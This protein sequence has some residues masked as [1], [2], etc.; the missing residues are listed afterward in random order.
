MAASHL[1]VSIDE[2]T[3]LART[4]LGE[5]VLGKWRLDR[6]IGV[7]GMAAVFE[8]THHNGNRVAIKILHPDLAGFEEIRERFL[9]EGYAANRV[10]HSGVVAVRDEGTTADGAVFLVMDL[11]RGQT[12]A[13]RLDDGREPFC[14][15]EV[16]EITSQLLDVLVHAHHRGIVHRDIKP[17]NV[18]LTVERR[19]RLL[20]FGIARVESRVRTHTTEA[21][22]TLGTPAFMPPEQALG[23][24]AELDGRSDLWSLGATMYLLLS[25]T[26]VREPGSVTEQLLGAMTRP[27]PSLGEVATLP[28]GVVAVVDRAL[29]FDRDARFPD[30]RSM[31]LA[32]RA[33]QAELSPPDARASLPPPSIEPMALSLRTPRPDGRS[34]RPSVPTMRPVAAT[35]TPLPGTVAKPSRSALPL[36]I[37]VGFAVGIGIVVAARMTVRPFTQTTYAAQPELRASA[38]APPATPVVATPPVASVAAASS[39]SVAPP[40]S[41]RR[42]PTRLPN[43]APR[44]PLSRPK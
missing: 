32:V 15:G 19:V 33:V 1:T 26:P 9:A 8:A 40:T 11:L 24:W 4:R 30:A 28:R 34:K 27:V 29:A 37:T 18:F 13:E 16:L 6:L 3:R 22:T 25:G 35:V 36:Y 21:G 17:E 31:Q 43:K 42:A 14:V 5:Q 2:R 44:D 41:A 20:D 10:S 7:G 23:R 38:A 12:L 39:A